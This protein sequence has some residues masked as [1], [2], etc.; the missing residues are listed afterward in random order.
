MDDRRAR[1]A[2]PDLRVVRVIPGEVISRVATNARFEIECEGERPVGLPAALCAKGYFSDAGR[3]FASVGRTEAMFYRDLAAASGVRTLEGMYADVDDEGRSVVIT[4]DAVAAGGRFLDALSPF[5]VDD[6]AAS[7]EELARLHATTW[8]A[9]HVASQTWL[10]SRL[11]TYLEFRGIDD[12]RKNF[13]GPNGRGVPTGTRATRDGWSRR[14]ACL[15]RRTAASAQWCVVHGDAH[16]GNVF[17]DTAGR[18]G[19]VDWQMV[20]RNPWYLDVGYHI[21]SALSV[22]ERERHERDLLAHYAERLRA[23]GVAPPDEQDIWSGY[24]MGIIHGFFLWGITLLVDPPIIEELLR[25]FGAAAEAHD[26]FAE[27]EA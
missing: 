23:G 24:R 14:F 27:L 22:E 26:A 16:V 21:A 15:G 9:E 4:A 8:Q 18:P 7:L 19:F 6:T 17:V 3:P 20:Q 11:P 2:F 1:I 12:I 13:D 5:S 10:E 25:R